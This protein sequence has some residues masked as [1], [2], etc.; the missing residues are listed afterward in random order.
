VTIDDK[1]AA[2]AATIAHMPEAK[3]RE[4]LEQLPAGQAQARRHGRRRRQRR[5]A[6]PRP[7]SM[8][9]RAAPASPRPSQPAGYELTGRTT[10]PRPP[11]G[12]GS[13]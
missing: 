5:S 13:A 12:S 8:I 1:L 7:D 4:R 2:A 9:G 3:V 10:P 6:V 11:A